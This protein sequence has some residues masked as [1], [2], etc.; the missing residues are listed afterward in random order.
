M[1]VQGQL[2]DVR[3]RVPLLN[4]AVATVGPPRVHSTKVEYP[5]ASRHISQRRRG[6]ALVSGA[7]AGLSAALA[8]A[9]AENVGLAQ[10]VHDG[11]RTVERVLVQAAQRRY[12]IVAR[13]MVLGMAS[14]LIR[15]TWIIET[16]ETLLYLGDLK[17]NARDPLSLHPLPI[18]GGTGTYRAAR[19][20]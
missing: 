7:H 17:S 5:L 3:H 12:E 16:L 1:T 11:V 18:P 9:S 8:G 6:S 14:Q 4:A 15:R 20:P 19:W 10:A 13:A 2:R